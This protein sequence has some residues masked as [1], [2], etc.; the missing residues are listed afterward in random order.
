MS[1]ELIDSAVSLSK[2]GYTW[3]YAKYPGGRIPAKLRRRHSWSEFWKLAGLKYPRDCVGPFLTDGK[4]DVPEYRELIEAKYTSYRPFETHPALFREFA[5]LELSGE[6]VRYFAD[7]WGVL[8]AIGNIGHPII[9]L[10]EEGWEELWDESPE[11]YCEPFGGWLWA[12]STMRYVLHLWDLLRANDTAVLSRA[13]HW[14]DSSS[15]SIRDTVN[16]QPR[17]RRPK[18]IEFHD[19]K[20]DWTFEIDELIAD[21][22]HK[23]FSDMAP[24]DVLI[25]A[26][27]FVRD[28]INWHLREHTSAQL[29]DAANASEMGIQL[30]PKNLFGA[31]WL[32]FAQAIDDDRDYYRCTQCRKWFE[33]APGSGR[34]DKQYCSNACRQRAYRNRKVAKQ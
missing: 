9:V 17:Y 1:L 24:G 14:N 12:I 8:G 4:V 22:E 3:V 2:E 31:L 21:E 23:M 26:L 15:V 6:A 32:Q 7:R 18:R 33:V 28:Q 16:P 27:V 20:K 25:P 30:V 5:E 19:F 11:F 29:N 34:P 10:F 13:I